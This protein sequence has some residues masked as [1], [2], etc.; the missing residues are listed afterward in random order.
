[1]KVYISVKSPVWALDDRKEDEASRKRLCVAGTVLVKI[2]CLLVVGCL[3]QEREKLKTKKY[4]L[5]VGDKRCA[6]DLL[7]KAQEVVFNCWNEKKRRC[8]MFK[9]LISLV[10]VMTLV[11]TAQALVFSDSF[12]YL[13]DNN[14]ENRT[15][16]QAWYMNQLGLT[17]PGM[18]TGASLG[19]L[20]GPGPMWDGYISI[21]D[22]V[23]SVPYTIAAANYIPTGTQGDGEDPANRFWR[24]GMDPAAPHANG[25]LRMISKG[26]GFENTDNTGAFLYKNVLGDFVAEVQVVGGDNMFHNLGGIMAREPN[27]DEYQGGANENWVSVCMFPLWSNGNRGNDTINGATSWVGIK[28]Y[29][30]EPYLRLIRSGNTFTFE[31]S[32]DGLAWTLLGSVVRDDLSLELQVGVY[33]SG[34]DSAWASTMEFDNFSIIP[35]PA[36]LALLGLGGLALIRKRRS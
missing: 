27:P 15:D 12:D 13:M 20:V 23:T 26:G 18:D 10:F 17:Y 4:C 34:F 36:T 14:W 7:S 32:P 30:P 6:F 9:R 25:V 33:K 29:P 28:G 35:E 31:C 21:P 2:L 3:R 8:L 24:P 19:G 1:V 11:G 22:L 5:P 16:Y